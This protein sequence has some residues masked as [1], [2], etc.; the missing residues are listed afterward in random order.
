MTWKYYKFLEVAKSCNKS[1]TESNDRMSQG[2]VFTC[3]EVGHTNVKRNPLFTEKTE[4]AWTRWASERKN[5][6]NCTSF[7]M[8][9]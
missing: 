9:L 4:E 3:K 1:N 2:F 5:S 6:Q 8:S 7:A